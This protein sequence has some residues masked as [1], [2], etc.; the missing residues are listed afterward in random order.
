MKTEWERTENGFG[1]ESSLIGV[2]FK[3]ESLKAI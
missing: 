2:S 1:L 3:Y